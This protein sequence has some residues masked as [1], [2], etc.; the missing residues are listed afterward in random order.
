MKCIE[1]LFVVLPSCSLKKQ[2]RRV[3]VPSRVRIPINFYNLH[4]EQAPQQ[5]PHLACSAVASLRMAFPVRAFSWLASCANAAPGRPMASASAA[6]GETTSFSSLLCNPEFQ[7]TGPAR[8][9]RLQLLLIKTHHWIS[10][11]YFEWIYL[12]LMFVSWFVLVPK[13]W[14]V[15]V[16]LMP[17]SKTCSEFMALNSWTRRWWVSV[18]NLS[19][20]DASFFMLACRLGS[21]RLRKAWRHEESWR[22]VFK[23]AHVVTHWVR[24]LFSHLCS[25]AIWFSTLSSS[26][27]VSRSCARD[28]DPQSDLSACMY[29][30]AWRYKYLH[31]KSA[32]TNTIK[33][34]AIYCI[35][36][37]LSLWHRLL[38]HWAFN[39]LVLL[40]SL[41]RLASPH[42]SV[43][44]CRMSYV[45]NGILH[46]RSRF[47]TWN[48]SGIDEPGH[49]M[50]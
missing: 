35:K 8:I 42:S 6:S 39:I 4:A 45:F 22:D 27:L 21:L 11:I 32:H 34:I 9:L 29:Y 2:I 13:R 26:W 23:I 31:T 43:V 25:M 49:N 37:S 5:N 48:I 40:C 38:R 33:S 1:L 46:G 47:S 44:W 24:I 30:Q 19:L 28:L 20:L 17:P 36:T 41:A 16:V 10:L 12:T 50:P 3:L 18:N 7:A 14:A 15:F